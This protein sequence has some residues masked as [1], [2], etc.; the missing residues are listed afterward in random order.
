M[1]KNNKERKKQ[2]RIDERRRREDTQRTERT[3]I[4]KILKPEQMKAVRVFNGSKH[5]NQEKSKE[6]MIECLKTLMTIVTTSNYFDEIVKTSRRGISRTWF[7]RDVDKDF[8]S[9]ILERELSSLEE[10]PVES[11][12]LKL[13]FWANRIAH[14]LEDEV[15][16][17]RGKGNMNY[18]YS[19]YFLNP[20]YRYDLTTSREKLEDREICKAR[21]T[22]EEILRKEP[23]KL[24]GIDTPEQLN[25]LFIGLNF[26]NE[27]WTLKHQMIKTILLNSAKKENSPIKVTAIEED[28]QFIENSPTLRLIIREINGIAPVIMHCRKEHIED[29]IR[30]NSLEPIPEET[31]EKLISFS[32]KS[33]IGIHF[34]MSEEDVEILKYEATD[35]SSA[36]RLQN[37][38]YKGE[39]D[40][41]GR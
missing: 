15:I 5:S 20:R 18:L 4:I 32:K 17:K 7:D 30:R 38:F 37:V 27:L 13:S 28:K 2:R 25:D 31:S 3:K 36:K 16:G 21:L 33:K 29:F 26:R 41:E 6:D 9:E 10:A 40:D 24:E 39:Q 11:I 19:K 12:A 8:I 14:H 35:R 34:V 23:K 22:L 1:K